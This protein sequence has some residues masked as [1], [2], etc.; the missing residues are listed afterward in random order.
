MKSKQTI[1]ALSILTSFVAS[2]GIVGA[3]K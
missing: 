2:I 3:K 1:I